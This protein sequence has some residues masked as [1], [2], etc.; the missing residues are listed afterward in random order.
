[1]DP[2]VNLRS[3]TLYPEVSDYPAGGPSVHSF[4]APGEVTLA[5]LARRQ[6]RYWL[7]IVPGR[8]VEYGREEA[9]KR[10]S[11]VTPEWPIAFTRLACSAEEFLSNFPCNHIHG[12]YG[13]RVQELVAVG[14]IL[15]IETRVFGAGQARP[16]EQPETEEPHE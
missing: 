14:K 15:D 2:K 16:G 12:V 6:G 7:A 10:G 11:T 13:D 3:V 9:L 1:M 4:A 8:I 5:R